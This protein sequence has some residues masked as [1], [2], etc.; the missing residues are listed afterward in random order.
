MS[1]R[2]IN[3]VI[4][5]FLISLSIFIF[6]NFKNNKVFSNGNLIRKIKIE[7]SEIY[8][9]VVLLP[10]KM[11]KGLGE[12]E[13]LCENCGMLFEFKDVARRSFWMKGM[14]F[15]LDIVWILNKRIVY[16]EKN[17]SNDSMATIYPKENADSVLEVNAG[18]SEKN[19]WKEGSVLK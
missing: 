9:E 4:I 13:F 11:A 12:R 17:I 19:G 14:R 7:K 8:V 5:L 16:I 3:I 1:K 18:F 6:M 15:P 10:E 2:I